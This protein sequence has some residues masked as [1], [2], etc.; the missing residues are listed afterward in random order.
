MFCTT[1]SLPMDLL[2][3]QGSLKQ[4][5]ESSCY[6]I[7]SESNVQ[8]MGLFQS[9]DER[10]QPSGSEKSEGEIS[11]V[12]FMS[13][14]NKITTFNKKAKQR[15]YDES[16]LSFGFTYFGNRDTPHAQCVLCKKVLSDSSLA[17]S[18]LRRHLETKHA[19][20]KDKDFSFFKQH[21]DSQKNNKPLTP[22]I[23]GID[24]ESATGASHNV[25]YHL[26]LSGEAHT[27]GELLISSH[28]LLYRHGLAVKIIPT[29]LKNVLDQAVQIITYIKA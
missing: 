6:Q 19:A 8:K 11:Q 28:C 27:I 4:E 12:K 29:S 24:N 17:P 20:H 7:L 5:V 1:N 23:V 26:A 18:K 15:K 3:K 14:S 10:L 2:P 21:L 13:N 22:K 16:Y 25:S 9:E